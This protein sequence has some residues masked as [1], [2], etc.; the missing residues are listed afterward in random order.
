[1]PSNLDKVTYRFKDYDI[2][3]SLNQEKLLRGAEA[4]ILEGGQLTKKQ[5]LPLAD[6]PTSALALSALRICRQFCANK[7]DVCAIVSAKS[8]RCSENCHFCAQSALRQGQ[9][10]KIPLISPQSALTTAKRAESCGVKRFSLVLSGRRLLDSELEQVMVIARLI[11]SQTKLSLCISA[12]L[13]HLDQLLALKQAGFSRVH[14]NLET[15]ESF[16]PHICTS[17]GFK[18]KVQALLNARQAGLEL[19]SGGIFGL[20]EGI[21]DRVELG[22]ALRELG[23]RSIPLNLLNPIPGTPLANKTV[24]STDEFIKSAALMRFILPD[25]YLRLA[26]GRTLLPEQGRPL[27]A[28]GVNAL[29]SGDMLTTTGYNYESDQRMLKDL[30]LEQCEV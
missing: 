23:I 17:H 10:P 6:L 20:G 2:K 15:S 11:K 1:M 7:C 5:L 14:N 25:S 3:L 27:F 9:L 13:L 26:G 12:G 30:N 24:L 16:F 4:L 21:A 19:C 18:D 29:I 8:G 22:L 28:A